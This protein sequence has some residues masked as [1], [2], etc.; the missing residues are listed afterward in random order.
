[1]TLGDALTIGLVLLALWVFV[2]ERYTTLRLEDGVRLGADAVRAA[3]R[4]VAPLVRWVAYD[5]IVGRESVKDEAEPAP[6]VLSS[7]REQQN[8]QVV[9]DT[10]IKAVSIPPLAPNA[11]EREI[12]RWLA[13]LK[14]ADTWRYSANAIY[15]LVKGNRNDVLAWVREARGFEDDEP[16]L[17]QLPEQPHIQVPAYEPPPR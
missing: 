17:V 16:P 11:T 5:V 15:A 4:R 13:G 14:T 8:A 9:S 10:S 1:M 3:W 12:V 7:R 6:D 2:V